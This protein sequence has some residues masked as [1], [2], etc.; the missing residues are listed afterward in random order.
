MANIVLLSANR[1]ADIFFDNIP[2][3]NQ[4]LS[5]EKPEA[6][7]LSFKAQKPQSD[8]IAV[9]FSSWFYC[10]DVQEMSLRVL[11]QAVVYQGK[12]GKRE[13]LPTHPYKKP[14]I[15]LT[16]IVAFL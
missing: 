8:F 16:N 11:P 5:S 4:T 7:L 13:V 6:L 2:Y 3:Q 1:F 14:R 9:G 12:G 15:L 10:K